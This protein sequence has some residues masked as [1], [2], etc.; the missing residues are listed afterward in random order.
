MQSG[1][2]RN[3]FLQVAS[4]VLSLTSLLSLKPGP[5]TDAYKHTG[6]CIR[7]L[8]CPRV[9]EMHCRSLSARVNILRLFFPFR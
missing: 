3:L 5:S 4:S 2:W 8:K 7:K 1:N 6:E 9:S